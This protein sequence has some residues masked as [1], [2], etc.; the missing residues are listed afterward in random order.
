M[1]APVG[2]GTSNNPK[3]ITWANFFAERLVGKTYHLAITAAAGKDPIAYCL[4]EHVLAD[5]E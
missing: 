4:L 1:F 2:L 3:T 5:Q